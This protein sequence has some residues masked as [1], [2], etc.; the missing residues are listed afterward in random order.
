[1]RRATVAKVSERH[2][3]KKNTVLLEHRFPAR[4]PV[5]CHTRSIVRDCLLNVG[6]PS[7]T[8]DDVVL[9]IDEACQNIIRHAYCGDSDQEIV[10]YISC[11]ESEL[12]IQLRD[13]APA[14]SPDCMKPRDLDDI[15]PGGL[16]S[17]LIQEIM[18]E[19]S[20]SPSVHGQGNVLR[21]TKGIAR[22]P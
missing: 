17:H 16:G 7:V 22:Y 9:A 6:C 5:L 14:V 18:D 19:V 8:V 1:M 2:G 15:R 21:M 13:F 10:L 4:A 3:T 11:H 20:I 12:E